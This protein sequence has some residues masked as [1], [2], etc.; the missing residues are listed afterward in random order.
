M[1]NIGLLWAI[2]NFLHVEGNTDGIKLIPNGR[3][4]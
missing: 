3:L 2:S 1:R 4:I